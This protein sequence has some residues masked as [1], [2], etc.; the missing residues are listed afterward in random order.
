MIISINL[1]EYKNKLNQ[2]AVNMLCDSLKKFS[3]EDFSVAVMHGCGGNFCTG[4]EDD[5]NTIIKSEEVIEVM[6]LLL[7]T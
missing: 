6:P 4:I 3:E 5:E 7:H 1:P 2:R